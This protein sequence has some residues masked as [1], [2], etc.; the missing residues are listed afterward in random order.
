MMLIRGVSFL[1]AGVAIAAC[2]TPGRSA[3]PP[4][5]TATLSASRLPTRLDAGI[6]PQLIARGDTVFHTSSCT[7]CHGQRAKGTPHGPDLTSGRYVQT[8]GSYQEIVKIITTGVPVDSIADPSFPEPMPP[9][10][11]GTPPLSDDQIR[12]LAAYV[13]SLGHR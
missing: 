13:Y 10:G 2:T 4:S 3:A 1:A 12:S 9:R 11:G 8:S 5:P 6:T 7:E